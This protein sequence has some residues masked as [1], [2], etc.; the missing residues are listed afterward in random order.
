MAP[1]NVICILAAAD[2]ESF[3]E[4]YK[5]VL[6]ADENEEDLISEMNRLSES[7]FGTETTGKSSRVFDLTLCKQGDQAVHAVKEALDA[8][9]PYA[10]AFLDVRMPLGQDGIRTVEQ[11]RA[12]DPFIEFVIVTAYSDVHPMDIS[13]RIPPDD[14]LLYVQK[15]FH[16]QEIHQFASALSSKWMADRELRAMHADLEKRI[17]E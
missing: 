9:R 15:P 4:L 3:L 6:E 1:N 16:P 7:L 5:A 2:E 10:V 17:E 11:I 14:K 12:F 8:N 13:E